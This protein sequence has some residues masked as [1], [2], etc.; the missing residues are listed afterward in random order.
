MQGGRA[1]QVAS[2]D[3]PQQPALA[4]SALGQAPG[5]E[6][7][8]AP[9]DVGHPGPAGLGHG[10]GR[11]VGEQ[12]MD[13]QQLVAV[14]MAG[15]PQAQAGTEGELPQGRHGGA[16]AAEGQHRHPLVALPASDDQVGMAA[17]PVVIGGEDG[18]IHA[19]LAQGGH[20]LDH[21]AARPAPQGADRGNHVQDLHRFRRPGC[22]DRFP[23]VPEN[24][25]T[26]PPSGAPWL[27]RN[28]PR[29]PHGCADVVVDTRR[30][31]P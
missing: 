6:L 7:A 14:Q 2:L 26:L 5:T 17:R 24:G 28:R 11:G 1:L 25:R 19:L 16:P 27:P 3:Q 15:Q 22:G 10:A 8:D 31:W 18:G 20:H 30:N 9:Q 23:P 4:A 21:G 12:G 29:S 13:V